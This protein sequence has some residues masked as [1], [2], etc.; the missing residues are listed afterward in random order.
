MNVIESHEQLKMDEFLKG[1]EKSE[2]LYKMMFGEEL[3]EANRSDLLS[4]DVMQV[5]TQIQKHI[6]KSQKD[7]NQTHQQE[8]GRNSI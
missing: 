2:H 3:N 6:E 5:S 4:L 1:K 7:S 8:I